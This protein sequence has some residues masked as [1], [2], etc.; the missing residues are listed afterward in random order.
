[1]STFLSVQLKIS[2]AAHFYLK[3]QLQNKEKTAREN[4][5]WQVSSCFA[6]DSYLT[7]LI[8]KRTGLALKR[9]SE[10]SGSHQMADSFK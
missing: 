4:A 7:V 5:H 1:M 10:Y 8:S 2:V 3:I 6:K 9:S